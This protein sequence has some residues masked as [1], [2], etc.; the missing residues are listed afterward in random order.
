LATEYPPP[1]TGQ[2]GTPP[3]AYEE[4]TDD[5][6]AEHAARTFTAH[7]TGGAITLRGDCLRCEHVMEYLIGDV[8][9]QWKSPPA[10][11]PAPPPEAEE[12][13]HMVCTCE[14]EHPNRPDGFL[15][16]GAYWDLA[17]SAP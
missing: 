10:T 2:P 4:K 8:V 13:E 16:C 12:P 9:R 11:P 15:G 3:L 5:R 14:G 6:Y 7:P 17:V 1:E